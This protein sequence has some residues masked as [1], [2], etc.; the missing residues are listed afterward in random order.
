MKIVTTFAD[1]HS[2]KRAI[3]KS[4]KRQKISAAELIRRATKALVDSRKLAAK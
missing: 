1:K 3:K 2:T 4:A